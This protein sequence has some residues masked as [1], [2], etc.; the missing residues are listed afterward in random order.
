MEKFTSK[1]PNII[2][3][4]VILSIILLGITYKTDIWLHT[5]GLFYDEAALLM[6]IKE[7][8]FLGLFL[9][10]GY[11][12]CAPAFFLVLQKIIYSIFGLK[13]TALY[14]IP[15]LSGVL[16]LIVCAILGNKIFKIK[17]LNILFLTLLTANTVINDYS[18]KLKQYSSDMFFAVLI[19]FLFLNFKDKIE[20]KKSVLITGFLAGLMCFISFPSQFIILPMIG[21]LIFKLVKNNKKELIKYLVLPYLTLVC[22]QF[23]MLVLGTLADSNLTNYWEE[24]EFALHSFASF[25]STIMFL[26]DGWGINIF[27]AQKT[28]II[29][30]LFFLGFIELCTKEKLLGYLLIAPFI[31]NAIS[32][33]LGLYPFAESRVILYLAPLAMI[34]C[35]KAFDF[36]TL[37]NKKTEIIFF[38]IFLTFFIFSYDKRRKPFYNGE[39]YYYF[40]CANA[41]EFVNKLNSRGIKKDDMI[42]LDSASNIAFQLYDKEN[43]YLKSISYEGNIGDLDDGQHFYIYYNKINL[44]LPEV[45]YETGK[46]IENEATILYKDSDLFGD[47]LY[48]K[49]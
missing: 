37:K 40:I 30:F 49:K 14:F 34:I 8:S 31:L 24:K 35:L 25:A 3:I 33:L 10:L 1:L 22:V 28:F 4:I 11:S 15:Y 9:P 39:N 20:S 36:L 27:T 23:F 43:K 7:R 12:Q 47:F 38:L 19:L 2:Y 48:I 32:G 45:H 16:T 17:S 26:V 29:G 21:Y 13:E 46:W 42:I 44:Y 18:Q 41:R 6:N 5:D